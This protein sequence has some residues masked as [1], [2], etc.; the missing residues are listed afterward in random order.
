MFGVVWSRLDLFG[1]VWNDSLSCLE[2]ENRSELFVIVRNC[3][4]L[5]RFMRHFA[6]QLGSSPKDC[7]PDASFLPKTSERC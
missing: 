1:V 3:S 6:D 4:K 2:L 5:P 7:L